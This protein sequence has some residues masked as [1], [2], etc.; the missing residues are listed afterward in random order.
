MTNETETKY[1]KI[2]I[3][4]TRKHHSV[5]EPENETTEMLFKFLDRN[6][7]EV[8]QRLEHVLV[9]LGK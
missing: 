4:L 3:E 8:K 6:L 9:L 7:T 1:R 2:A 5:E